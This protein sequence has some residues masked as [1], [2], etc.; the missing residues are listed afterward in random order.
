MARMQAADASP[1]SAGL[2]Q[3]PP[4]NTG[5]QGRFEGVKQ[6]EPAREAAG[7]GKPAPGSVEQ[8]PSAT[9]YHLSSPQQ[10][11]E[12]V[13]GGPQ[14]KGGASPAPAGRRPRPAT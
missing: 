2:G 8:R 10:P 14:L 6:D 5:E 3:K 1:R 12:T 4:Q 9:F 13:Y 7:G 11:S